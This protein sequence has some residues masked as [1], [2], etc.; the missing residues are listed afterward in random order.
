MIDER[1]PDGIGYAQFSDCRRFRYR[2]SRAIERSKR[3]DVT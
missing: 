2:L 1:S 3:R